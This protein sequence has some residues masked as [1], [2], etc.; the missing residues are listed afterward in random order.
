MTT[1]K[2]P[3]E[4]LLNRATVSDKQRIS[5]NLEICLFLQG[6]IDGYSCDINVTFHEKH[7][8]KFEAKAGEYL[9]GQVKS[10]YTS[11]ARDLLR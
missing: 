10:K 2:K 4:S 11:G 7:L 1:F 8:L 3:L 9:F 6:P 5:T